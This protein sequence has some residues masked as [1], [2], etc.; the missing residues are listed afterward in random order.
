MSWI[1]RLGTGLEFVH[2]AEMLAAESNPY[3]VVLPCI[4]GSRLEGPLLLATGKCPE[5][6]PFHDEKSLQAYYE[7]FESIVVFADER[8]TDNARKLATPWRI[9]A[10][11][12]IQMTLDTP[13]KDGDVKALLDLVN[14][15]AVTAL[16]GPQSLVLVRISESY[17]FYRGI[18]NR[19]RLNTSD[20]A[21]G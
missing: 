2:G 6:V 1:V 10:V 3:A 9:N 17:C 13:P 21:F 14:I 11:L 4:Y 15:N 16:A 19:I 18:A 20:L 5:N 12:I 7:K 8:M